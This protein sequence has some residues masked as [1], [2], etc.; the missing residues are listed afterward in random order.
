[1]ISL[2]DVNS[3]KAESADLAFN[4]SENLIAEFSQVL[5]QGYC[6]QIGYS[7][8]KDSTVIINAAIEAMRRCIESGVIA[9]DHPLVAITVDTLQEPEP[10][11]AYVP[12]VHR[13]ISAYCQNLGINL[14]L[15]IVSPPIYEEL[16]VLFAG[17]QKLPATSAS[18]RS[19]DCSIIWKVDT[20]IRALKRIKSSLPKIYQNTTWISASGSRSDESSRRSKN[21]KKQGVSD[22]KATHLINQ[23]ETDN[24][25]GK[26]KGVYK[27]APIHDWDT[28]EVISYLHHAGPNPISSTLVNKRIASYGTNFG[29]LLAIYG[30]GSNEVCEVISLDSENKA[31]QKGCGKI[32]RFGC[33]T[34]GMVSEDHSSIEIKQYARWG[35]FGNNTQ[36]FRD[37]IIRVSSDVNQRAF[38]ARAYDPM[39]NNNVFLQPNTLKAR[40]LE[41]MVFYSS[42]ITEDMK[43]I[44]HDFVASVKNGTVNSDVGIVDIMNDETLRGD[45]KAEYVQM[46]TERLAERP[47]FE[48]FTEKHALLLSL[49]W[50]LHGVAALPYRPIAILD[51]VQKGERIPF[52]LTNQELNE[53]RALMG[54]AKWNDASVLERTIPDALVAQVFEPSKLSFGQLKSQFGDELNEHHLSPLLP[55][56]ISAIH[57]MENIQFDALGATINW[58]KTRAYNTR[59]FKL[60]YSKSMPEGVESIKAKDHGT[61]RMMDLESNPV[62]KSE[63]LELARKE[64]DDMIDLHAVQAGLSIKEAEEILS[65]AG[66]PVGFEVAHSFNNQMVYTSDVKFYSDALRTRQ[67]R[68]KQAS[69]RKR[70]FNKKTQSYEAHRASLRVYKATAESLLE[71]QTASEVS[72][73]LPEFTMVRENAIDIHQVR[74]INIDDVDNKFVFDDYLFNAFLSDGGWAKIVATHNISLNKS[75]REKKPVRRYYGSL[76][77]YYITN[78]TGLSATVSF[79]SYMQSTLKRTELFDH[80]GLYSLANQSYEKLSK[81]PYVIG[82]NEHREQK[83]E[84]LLATRYLRNSRRTSIK[85]ALRTHEKM[86]SK[87]IMV[88]NNVTQRLVKFTEQYVDI[89]TQYIA[90]NTMSAFF[91]SCESR[92]KLL[93]M[94]LHDYSNI[95]TSANKALNIL[96]TTTER[97]IINQDF[98]TKMAF[99][100]AVYRQYV[101]AGGKIAREVKKPLEAFNA[102]Q[103]QATDTSIAA[104][105]A[106]YEPVGIIEQPMNVFSLWIKKFYSN[107][108]PYGIV[109]ALARN[110]AF[111]HKMP[112][113]CP[114]TNTS[115]ANAQDKLEKRKVDAIS[116]TNAMRNALQ[117]STYSY[118]IAKE[119]SEQAQENNLLASRKASL[120]KMS[121]A[122]KNEKLQSLMKGSINQI[123]AM[124][125]QRSM[126]SSKPIVA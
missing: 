91:T 2:F 57:T 88:L 9:K 12:F 38:H 121:K 71:K 58:P 65:E 33:V 72:Y 115:N 99:T 48:F 89:S 6:C 94:W 68:N 117:V 87:Q 36:R 90:A 39:A 109:F 124:R 103:D 108:N 59:K 66:E 70:E 4:M 83:I 98:D 50:S 47:M 79:E 107:I 46:Y 3:I 125:N 5:A 93:E 25:N 24:E 120:T 78:N 74:D 16:M 110:I 41:K 73:W 111:T 37:Y 61:G 53:K 35:R 22:L 34:C 67:E 60:S 29:L 86:S 31:E 42:Q 8:G 95:L 97:E 114:V 1:M 44:H 43:A 106:I 80:A 55:R 49:M 13:A 105:S 126:Q 14:F 11:Q 19:A 64:Y 20:S 84:H 17:A 101:M 92:Q 112:Y 81:H 51:K 56:T 122:A 118:L 28:P 7:G 30:E 104:F 32:A 62:L 102:I 113:L 45:V 116:H 85:N 21:M 23:I 119:V 75:L 63:L 100:N 10:I 54:L 27:F 96:A 123:A 82:M 76:P 77:V 18:G 15:E 69:M 52:P 40:V 26:A